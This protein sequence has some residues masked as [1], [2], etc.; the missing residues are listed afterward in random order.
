VSTRAPTRT[1]PAAGSVRTAGD[2]ESAARGADVRRRS[3]GRTLILAG[4]VLAVA[5]MLAVPVRSWLSQRAE[6]DQ[7]RADV[8]ASQARVDALA[9]Q[10]D[11][12]EDPR[13]VALQART[14]LNMVKPG[15][16]ALIVLDPQEQREQAPQEPTTLTGYDRLWEATRSV[17]GPGQVSSP[18]GDDGG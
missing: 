5:L 2:R 4:A 14:R 8:A 18:D 16:S 12:W 6:L 15:E 17:A 13:H 3:S 9:V 11:R 7:L 1:S 10:K